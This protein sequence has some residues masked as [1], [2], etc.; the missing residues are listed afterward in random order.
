MIAQRSICNSVAYRL[1]GF[2]LVVLGVS[3]LLGCHGKPKATRREDAGMIAAQRDAGIADAEAVWPELAKLP[4]VQPVRVIALP[5]RLDVPRFTVGGPVLAG[6]V[7][8]VSSSQFGFI[9]VDY[10]RGQIAWTKPA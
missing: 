9:A 8:V 6:D 5:A 1:F 3:L 4:S 2:T 7:A 10:E